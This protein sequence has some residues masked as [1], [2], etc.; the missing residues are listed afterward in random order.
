M[1]SLR[2]RTRSS[3]MLKLVKITWPKLGRTRATRQ[4]LFQSLSSV[5]ASGT[6]KIPHDNL[7]ISLPG[8]VC[9]LQSFTD[10]SLTYSLFILWLVSI[11]DVSLYCI[12][13]NP[14][15]VFISFQPCQSFFFALHF[16]SVLRIYS[17][18]CKPS[19]LIEETGVF[20][21]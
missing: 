12:S 13:A 2:M 4:S 17:D 3:E 19:L 21:G 7:Q 6:P 14:A 1:P 10:R 20:H 16:L 9:R 15:T 5:P 11:F 18:T 8:K